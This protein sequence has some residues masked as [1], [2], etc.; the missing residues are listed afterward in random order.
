MSQLRQGVAERVGPIANTTYD[1][2]Y[3]INIFV[4]TCCQQICP[5]NINFTGIQDRTHFIHTRIKIQVQMGILNGRALQKY[6]H[7][8]NIL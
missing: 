6:G 3:R 1:I 2:F 7:F 8:E 4:V 5:S